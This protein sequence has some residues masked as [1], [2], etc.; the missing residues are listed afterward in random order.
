MLN[1]ESMIKYLSDIFK[2]HAFDFWVAKVDSSIGQLARLIYLA[3][4]IQSTNI[5]PKKQIAA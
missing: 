4:K 5:Q 3:L 1:A 2:R